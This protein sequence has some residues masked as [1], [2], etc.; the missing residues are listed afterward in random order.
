VSC[1]CFSL[2]NNT[3]LAALCLNSNGKLA[4][5]EI[6]LDNCFSNVNGKFLAGGAHFS[7]SAKDVHLNGLTLCA[8]LKKENG[9]WVDATYNLDSCIE[10]IDGTLLFQK[11]YVLLLPKHLWDSISS[12]LSDGFFDRDG[13]AVRFLQNVPVVGFIVAGIDLA[14]GDP[15]DAKRAAADATYSTIITSAAILASVFTGPIGI[16]IGSALAT[17]LAIVSEDKIASTIQDPA[18]RDTFPAETLDRFLSLTFVNFIAAGTGPYLGAWAGEQ[19][20]TLFADESVDGVTAQ[21]G[22]VVAKTGGRQVGS[23]GVKEYI[24]DFS[25]KCKYD[26]TMCASSRGF[27]RVHHSLRGLSDQKD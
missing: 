9:K 17:P 23:E 4:V 11:Q 22:E 20:G 12:L 5:A 8:S 10:N 1:T 24:I 7:R 13:T 15:N 26:L 18:I 27:D 6:D 14:K 16:A 19:A 2:K 21:V 3:V 25:C